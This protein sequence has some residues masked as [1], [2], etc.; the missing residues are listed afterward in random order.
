VSTNGPLYK[1]PGDDES[2]ASAMRFI[3]RAIGMDME[4]SIPARVIS[5]N[6]K[7]N[8]ATV[9]PM[10]VTTL[11][12]PKGGSTIQKPRDHIPDIPVLS[13][14]AGNYHIS[15]PINEGDLGWLHANDRDITVYLQSLQQ[16]AAGREGPSHSFSDGL[17]IPDVLRQYVINP[18]D[19]GAMVIQS[20]DGLSRISIRQDNIKITTPIRVLLDT[21][22]VETTKDMKVGGSLA[23]LG[24]TCTLPQ[25]T[26]TGGA[27]VYGHTHDGQVPPFV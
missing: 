19:D 25:G 14:G 24:P 13:L 26:T 5:F 11:L 6:R 1:R 15:F 3:Q 22:L 12:D 9:Q 18:E 17:F 4:N 16:S 10:I 8:T 7:L 21:P 23:V 2:L 20:T 27:T